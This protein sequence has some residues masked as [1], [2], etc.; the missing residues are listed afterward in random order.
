MNEII[1]RREFTVSRINNLRS[2]LQETERLV[3][4]RACVYATGSFGRREAS[5]HSD[6]DLF[7]VGKSVDR[8]DGTKE[9][10]LYSG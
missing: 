8:K 5:A 10:V 9:S 4:E 3:S 6:L 2:K 7:I 1:K